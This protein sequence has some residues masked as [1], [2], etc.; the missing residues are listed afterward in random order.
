MVESIP[1]AERHDKG[2]LL[3]VLCPLNATKQGTYDRPRSLD[4]MGKFFLDK[5]LPDISQFCASQGFKGNRQD[6]LAGLEAQ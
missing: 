1:K 3:V 6:F 5:I 4:W 2:D